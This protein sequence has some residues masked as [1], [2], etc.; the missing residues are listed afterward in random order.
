MTKRRRTRR[1]SSIPAHLRAEAEQ[2]AAARA[3]TDQIMENIVGPTPTVTAKLDQLAARITTHRDN[4]APHVAALLDYEQTLM[5]E[6]RTAFPDIDLP[7]LG[8]ILLYVGA[9]MAE[10]ATA[11]PPE[12]RPNAAPI[13][14]NIVQMAGE[15]FWTGKPPIVWECPHILVG[16]TKCTKVLTA[17][18]EEQLTPR[19]A[20][21]LELSHPDTRA[22]RRS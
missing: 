10:L 19:V 13:I 22:E 14:V 6:L 16:G 1:P 15:R 21:H 20:G 12:Q 18:D 9:R 5:A 8:G 3:A 4:N 2:T 17:K 11:L 7:Q